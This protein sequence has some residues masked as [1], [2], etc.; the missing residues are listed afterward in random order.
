MH[1]KHSKPD[2]EFVIFVLLCGFNRLLR[3]S[4]PS[5]PVGFAHKGG[6]SCAE[7]LFYVQ[8]KEVKD[9]GRTLKPGK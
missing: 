6:T 8:T 3:Q 7:P 2:Y 9:T 5:G 1:K 4:W